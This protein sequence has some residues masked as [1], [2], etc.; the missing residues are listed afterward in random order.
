MWACAITIASHLCSPVIKG[1]Y[2]LDI[3][4][5]AVAGGSCSGKSTMVLNAHR[6]LGPE[7]CAIVY[8]DSYY[9]G[10]ANITNFDEPEAIDFDLMAD[11]L[12]QLKRGEAIDMPT[13]DFT[14][15]RRKT[16]TQRL[17]PKPIIL[18]DGILILHAAQ[19]ADCFDYKLYVECSEE[20]RLQRRLKRDIE[21]RG[22]THAD[23]YKQF[24]EQVAPLHN[25]LVEPSKQAADLICQQTPGGENDQAFNAPLI[26]YCL[27]H[28]GIPAVTG[29]PNSNGATPKPQV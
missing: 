27:A 8:Q 17:D 24:T 7:Q 6:T 4:I 10:L 18:V 15:H 29:S 26:N 21:E 19:L 9:K 22:R 5:I 11:H 1:H 25:V 14:T 28:T 12:R 23:T 2:S 20:E 16:E 3:Q 13:Y